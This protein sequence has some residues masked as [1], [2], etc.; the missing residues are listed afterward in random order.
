MANEEETAVQTLA[1]EVVE[2]RNDLAGTD[3]A[4]MTHNDRI[5]VVERGAASRD[6]L[7]GALD[8]IE[9]L[10][11][12]VVSREDM[13]V[14]LDRISDLARR[15]TDETERLNKIRE[16][17]HNHEDVL[18]RLTAAQPITITNPENIPP[19]EFSLPIGQGVPD[20]DN[21][22]IMPQ[23]GRHMATRQA[24]EQR[25]Y[26]RGYVQGQN[27][28]VEPKAAIENR[29]LADAVTRVQDYM[30]N[31]FSEATIRG[32]VQVIGAYGIADPHSM[33]VYLSTACLHGQHGDCDID[34]TRWDGTHKKAATCKYCPKKCIC[35]HHL[36]IQ[37]IPVEDVSTTADL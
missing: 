31:H 5:S 32:V 26:N 2:L 15:I 20:F 1:R 3:R 33:H 16:M 35:P 37:S 6:G 34:A 11:S 10:E 22:P 19:E 18:R 12:T 23:A 14:A 29:T 4:V 7:S 25:A 13:L 17:V 21:K 28:M 9:A 27:S 24:I 36:Q 8:R 30:A